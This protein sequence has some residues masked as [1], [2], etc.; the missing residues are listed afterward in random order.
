M[1]TLTLARGRMIVLQDLTEKVK[2]EE[3]R[4]D[5]FID[6]G[7]EFQTPL[8]VIRTGLEMLMS[9]GSGNGERGPRCFK[10]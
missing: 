1:T 7:H 10:A 4:R 6:A 8:T 2:L 3:A 5:F 9:G